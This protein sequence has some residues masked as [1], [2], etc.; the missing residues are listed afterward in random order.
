MVTEKA[1]NLH[2][3][4]F[5]FEEFSEHR[6]KLGFYDPFTETPLHP[7]EIPK[8]IAEH[9]RLNAGLNY[10]AGRA[11]DLTVTIMPAPH[12]AESVHDGSDLVRAYSEHDVIFFEG[13]GNTKAQRDAIW[14]VSAGKRTS[15]TDDEAYEF[16]DYGVRKVAA[17]VGQ[18]KPAFFADM[19]IDGD[20]YEKSLIEWGGVL[21]TLYEQIQ[22]ASGE[23]LEN[24]NLTAGIN[25]AAVTILREWY[26][27]ANIG[28][29]LKDLEEQ[30]GYKSTSP[31][32]LIG[33]LHGQTLPFKLQKLGVRSELRLPRMDSTGEKKDL[34]IPFDLVQALSHYAVTY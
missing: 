33:E 15:L 10:L 13:I 8:S 3:N 26:I 21:D 5:V 16:G 4:S 11:N 32:L 27:L 6:K 9:P 12:S 23:E 28:A 24:L 34:D 19:P 1:I 20:E 2:H 7:D 31:M 29:Q 25:L 18:N 17:L 30:A 14:D 22:H